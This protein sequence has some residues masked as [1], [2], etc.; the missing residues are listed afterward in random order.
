MKL[1]IKNGTLVLKEREVK[2]DLL[3]AGSKILKIATKITCSDNACNVIDASG[4]HVLPGI[5][6]LHVH[7]REPEV[8]LPSGAA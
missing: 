8:W 5:I 3:I 2:A 4:K 6:D 7:L 1:L